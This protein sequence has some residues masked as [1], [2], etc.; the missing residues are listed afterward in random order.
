[1]WPTL[2]KWAEPKFAERC[3]VLAGCDDDSAFA[4]WMEG[5]AKPAGA[6]PFS[7]AGDARISWE[8]YAA[9]ASYRAEIDRVLLAVRGETGGDL[10]S[11]ML[12]AD[13]K[14]AVGV[15]AANWALGRTL[16]ALGI[17][18]LSIAATGRARFAAAA[19]AGVLPLKDAAVLAASDGADGHLRRIRPR[20]PEV[21]MFDRAGR[22]VTGAEA[23]DP[24]SWVMPW[25]MPADDSPVVEDTSGS[26]SFRSIADSPSLLRLLGELWVRGVSI[27]WPA[28]YPKGSVRRVP[29]PG[30]PLQ[31]FLGC[32]FQVI[33]KGPISR[34][35]SRQSPAYTR[36]HGTPALPFQTEP[37]Q[38]RDP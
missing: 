24:S 21:P 25:V 37:A 30:Y 13:G 15:F 5:T 33:E 11:T 10:R 34:R 29:L 32:S 23:L 20:P 14:P 26:I 8:L 17:V 12:L 16:T 19:L 9:I 27:E 1:M 2:C 22:T 28:L 35:I 7:L 38:P 6:I 36:L 18:P 3:A 31:L 4:D